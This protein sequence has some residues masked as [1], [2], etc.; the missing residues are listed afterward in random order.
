MNRTSTSLVFSW[1]VS[2]VQEAL[3]SQVKTTRSGG[4]TARTRAHTHI[5]TVD[6]AVVDATAGASFEHGLVDVLAAEEVVLV[7]L[8][9][10]ELLGE[11]GERAGLGRFYDD[12]VLDR[13]AGGLAAHER[14]S[15]GSSTT[16]LKRRQRLAPE[17][18]E[19]GAQR[20][21]P[22]RLDVVDAAR[23]GLRV[24]HQPGV[25]EHL[26]VLGDGG[27]ADRQVLGQLTDRP[28]TLEQPLEDVPSRRVGERGPG[29]GLVSRHEP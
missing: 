19:L 26:Q 28:G 11:D 17:P 22:V 9:A 24:R 2:G 4:S 1:S 10:V 14:S 8:D 5:A 13:R 6:A 29:V 25:L 15:G 23:A 3:M 20:A 27:A 21:Q 7:R 16:A 18:V 12:R